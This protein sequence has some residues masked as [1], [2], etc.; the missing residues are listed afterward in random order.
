MNSFNIKKLKYDIF[1][2]YYNQFLCCK[3]VLK[4]NLNLM[5]PDDH[6][7]VDN[8]YEDKYKKD[9]K[10]IKIKSIFKNYVDKI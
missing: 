5:I 1:C 9:P 6:E 7:I 3:D 4:N 2:N 10:F 8:S